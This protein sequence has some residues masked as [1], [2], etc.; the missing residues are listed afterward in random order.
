MF[1]AVKPVTVE[2]ILKDSHIGHKKMVSQDRWSVKIGGSSRLLRDHLSNMSNE[3]AY[4]WVEDLFF[5]DRF[6]YTTNIC[7][8]DSLISN[9]HVCNNIILLWSP[10]F[11]TPLF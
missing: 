7:I 4:F 1:V 3:R 2:P 10:Q 6:H 5:Q 8:T 9:L 11:K